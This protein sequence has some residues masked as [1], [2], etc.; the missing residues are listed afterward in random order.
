MSGEKKAFNIEH[1]SERAPDKQ[2]A[3]EHIVHAAE[4]EDAEQ[5]KQRILE[6]SRVEASA[7]SPDKQKVLRKI[8][9]LESQTDD[10]AADIPAGDALKQSAFQKEI[11]H[12]RRKL[13]P[14]EKVASKFIHQKVVRSISDVSAKTLTRPSGL[15]GGGV[16]A[17]LGTS[18]YIYLTKD[19][20]IKYNYTVFLLLLVI[21]FAVGLV[22]E[23]IIRLTKQRKS[24]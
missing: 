4:R 13:S 23:A 18:A 1:V 12:I 7:N 24:I 15:L 17:F 11:R 16:V 8:E 5:T 10:T 20:G 9:S 2:E 3:T 21:G 19:I 6:Q 22:L 14:N